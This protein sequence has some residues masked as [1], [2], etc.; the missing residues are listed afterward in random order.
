MLEKPIFEIE[1]I[2]INHICGDSA[3]DRW[4]KELVQKKIAELTILDISRMLRQNIFLD[5]AI[6]VAKKWIETDPNTGEM[7]DGQLAE[8]LRNAEKDRGTVLL[9]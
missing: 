5:I 7:Y 3:L 6:P 8:L 2:D 1:G 4:F 9:S